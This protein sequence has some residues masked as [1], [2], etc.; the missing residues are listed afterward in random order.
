MAAPRVELAGRSVGKMVSELETRTAEWTAARKAACWAD[1]SAC[2]SAGRWD[3]RKA[4]TTGDG[5]AAKKAQKKGQMT[6]N[7]MA[8]AWVEQ[9]VGG[10]AGKTDRQTADSTVARTDGH[11]A[12]R[13]GSWWEQRKVGCRVASRA[14]QLAGQRAELPAAAKADAT[15]GWWVRS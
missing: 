9:T 8:D 5:W 12:A 11:W 7:T 15:V 3:A 2:R 6:D 13:W 14:A 1:K 10:W 4:G